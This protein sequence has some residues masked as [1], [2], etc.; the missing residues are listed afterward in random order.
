MNCNHTK[1]LGMVLFAL[2]AQGAWAQ[3]APSN[4]QNVVPRVIFALNGSPN[5]YCNAGGGADDPACNNAALNAGVP[6]ALMQLAPDKF[7]A[8]SVNSLD[9]ARNQFSIV[10]DRLNELNSLNL[11]SGLFGDV[12]PRSIT[13]ATGGTTAI[14]P[15]SGPGSAAAGGS[16]GST[17]SA[18]AGG[19]G[20][21]GGAA[22]SS[23]GVPAAAEA[24][25]IQPGALGVYL[26]LQGRRDTA[27]ANA[28]DPAFKTRVSGIT[29]GADYLVSKQG[30]V[31]ASIGHDRNRSRL[32]TANG[33]AGG[34]LETSGSTLTLYGAFYPSAMSY[35]DASLNF[36]RS[37]YKS[38]RR[39]DIVTDDGNA[40][41]DIHD[42]AAGSTRGRQIGLSIGGGANW[43]QERWNF[44]PYARMALVTSDIDAFTERPNVSKTELSV[45]AQSTTSVTSNIGAQVS[46]AWS[47]GWGVLAP[48]ARLEWEHQF[49]QDRSRNLVASFA[50]DTN[51]NPIALDTTPPDRNHLNLG[52]GLAAHFGVGKSAFVYYQ[53]M[54]GNASKKSHALTF[55]ARLEF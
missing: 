17:G 29:L 31:G 1:S 46:Y 50:Q 51:D 40:D 14:V 22:T 44:G 28:F 34:E 39:I 6:S 7:V 43:A 20:Q 19:S 5:A 37:R 26:R 13:S 16:G 45:Q 18:G 4:A 10:S 15:L 2:A 53:T 54:I 48:S 24:G 30:V 32:G 27:K 3:S 25:A 9:L 33:A 38:Q 41:N 8:F 49:R 42:G 12:V 52:L 11:G 21:G 23:S 35:M 55:E 47:Q 36:G